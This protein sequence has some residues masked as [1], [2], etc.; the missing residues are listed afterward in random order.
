MV[1]RAAKRTDTVIDRC[2]IYNPE[3]KSPPIIPNC[4]GR[5]QGRR[6]S[7]NGLQPRLAGRWADGLAVSLRN[8]PNA[9]L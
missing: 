9:I 3:R 5:S 8:A 2:G 4:R 6:L 1:R 7:D